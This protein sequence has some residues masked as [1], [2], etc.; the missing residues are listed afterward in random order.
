MAN[1]RD[2]NLCTTIVQR[3]TLGN[4]R[5]GREKINGFSELDYPMQIR[6]HWHDIE[7]Y[8]ESCGVMRPVKVKFIHIQILFLCVASRAFRTCA[9]MA[10]YNVLCTSNL[11]LSFIIPP[12]Y[13]S[14]ILLEKFVRYVSPCFFFFVAIT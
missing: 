7:T 6:Q 3:F 11:Y 4:R 1:V 13:C 5:I 9:I 2:F 12:I 8:G 10:L 14:A